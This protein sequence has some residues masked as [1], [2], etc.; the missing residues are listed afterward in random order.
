[1]ST[2]R[3][4]KGP[5]RILVNEL[6]VVASQVLFVPASQLFSVNET[7]P[8]RTEMAA[9][10]TAPQHA[11]RKALD[12]ATFLVHGRIGV[13]TACGL[14][15]E[16]SFVMI[17][18]VSRCTAKCDNNGIN[19]KKIFG[20]WCSRSDRGPRRSLSHSNLLRAADEVFS[21]TPRKLCIVSRE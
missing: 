2:P 7:V 11:K 6:L 5:S 3:K 16:A 21:S 18:V 4:L 9:N 15:V 13:S 19:A 14:D 17:N 1:M 12:D 10:A 20:I 8:S